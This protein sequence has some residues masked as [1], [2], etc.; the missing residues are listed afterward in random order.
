MTRQLKLGAFL[1]TPGNHAGGWRH[2]A[3]I[4]ETDMDFALY[5]KLAQ[6]AERGKLDAVF[7]QDTAAIADDTLA[8]GGRNGY[9]RVSWLEPVTLIAALAAVTRDI[10]LIS[11]ATTSYNEPYHVARKFASIDH[12]SG[13]RAGWNLVTSQIENESGNFGRDQHLEHAARYERAGEFYDVVRGLW[14]GWEDGALLRDKDSAIYFDTAKVHRLDHRGRHFRVRGP[15]NVARSPQ[16]RPVVSQAGSSPAGRDLAARSAD[17]VF[18]AAVTLD[19]AREFYAD[20][21]TRTAAHGRNPD[22]IKIL[23]GLLP[24]VGRSEAEAHEKYQ[25]LLDLLPAD[26]GSKPI[27]RLAG[28][29]DLSK[30]PLDGPLPDLPPNNSAL[31]RQK[32]LVDLARRDNLTIRQLAKHFACA[33]GHRFIYGTPARIADEMQHWLDNDGADGFNLMFP[34]F[35]APLEEFVDLVVPELQRRGIFRTAYEGRTLRENL[36]IPRPASPHAAR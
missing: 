23:P 24:I 35:P 12:I 22:H 33:G 6:T 30:Y 10:G 17:L 1:F 7:F 9:A 8:D 5:A 15:L 11:T 16:G 21:K 13:G 20:V 25:Q 28:E 3:A 27:N 29:L 34:H 19:E 2:P 36:G 18:T 14:D 4:P 32:L 31:G 26:L